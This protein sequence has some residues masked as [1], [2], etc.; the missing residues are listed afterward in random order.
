MSKSTSPLV[1]NIGEKHRV[2][3]AVNNDIFTEKTKI[4]V[5]KLAPP[6]L[7]EDDP[8][9]LARASPCPASALRS[10]HQTSQ[11]AARSGD[12][13]PAARWA[14][15]R[16]AV[17]GLTADHRVVFGRLHDPPIRMARQ[18]RRAGRTVA[19][20]P[21]R[22]SG[23]ARSAASV[24]RHA[25]LA[26]ITVLRIAAIRPSGSIGDC[27]RQSDVGD[28]GGATARSLGRGAVTG[29]GGVRS[30]A[31]HA[32]W[33]RFQPLTPPPFQWGTV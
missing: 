18:G 13:R 9:W 7:A 27:R 25:A 21:S 10:S 17:G 33:K 19:A 3:C 26:R 31:R 6:R 14:P 1:D 5:I 15:R 8:S 29:S 22:E 28:G 24:C 23:L 32:A 16:N 30:A 11:A 20:R 12:A 2:S 4:P